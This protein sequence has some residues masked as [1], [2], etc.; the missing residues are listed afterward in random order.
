MGLPNFEFVIGNAFHNAFQ[1]WLRFRDELLICKCE[2]TESN[3]I[4]VTLKTTV[5]LNEKK[6][7]MATRYLQI[8]TSIYNHKNSIHTKFKLMF[9]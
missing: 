9:S 1:G 6:C 3:K 5:G 7:L 8:E 2:I 4:D